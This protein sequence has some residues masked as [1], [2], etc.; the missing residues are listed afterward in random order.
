MTEATLVKVGPE[1]LSACGIGC[2]INPRHPGFGPKVEWLRKRF[3]EG[4][5][6]LLFRDG[7]G[8]PLAFLEYVPGEFVW[9]PLAAP[10]W[11]VVHCLWVYPAG[12]KVGGLGSRLIQA[13]VEEAKQADF[14]GVAAMV[15]DGPWMAGPE[16]FL[17]NG[18][19]LVA[20]ADRFQLVHRRLKEGAVPRF[21]EIRHTAT[22][23]RGLHIVYAPQC[24]LLIK[25]VKDLQAVAAENG[26]VV[27][28]TELDSAAAAQR[29]PSYYGV[30][31]LLW[32]GRLLSDHYVSRGR[33]RNILRKEILPEMF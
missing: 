11:L 32:N 31:S 22:V 25:S 12:M 3:D 15:S 5:R 24:P 23:D 29:A 2:T 6:F 27:K 26:L 20:A 9:R 30:F 1:N 17:K 16:V 21:R 19:H 7:D 28:I 14:T 13:C 33:F 18:F 8:K 10:G 4:L